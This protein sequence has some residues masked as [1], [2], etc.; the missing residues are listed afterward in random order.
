MSSSRLIKE[1]DTD[2]TREVI[3]FG[4]KFFPEVENFRACIQCGTCTGS[5]PS[6]RETAWRVRK[7]IRQV[8]LGLKEDAIRN[9]ALWNCT[10]CYTCSESALHVA[11]GR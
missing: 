11:S 5:C 8:Q 10:T 2:F 1:F 7:L 3:D 6:G 9:D 4:S